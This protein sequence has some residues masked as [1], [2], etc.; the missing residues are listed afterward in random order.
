MELGRR[1]PA[2][3]AP[4][5]PGGG[6]RWTVLT[7]AVAKVITV[8]GTIVLA[9]ILVPADFGIVMLAFVA[10]NVIGLFGDLGLGATL[11]VRQDLDR[12]GLGTALSLLLGAGTLLGLVLAA[13]A[14]LLSDA[15]DE[16]RLRGV[17]TALAPLTVL[18]GLTWFYQWLLQRDLAFRT[19]F[20]GFVAQAAVY[21]AVAVGAAALG[22]G[23][24]S[25]V[26]GHLAGQAAMAAVF[27]TLYRPVWPRFDLGVARSLLRT[28]RGFLLQNTATLA[29]QNADYLA[30]GHTMGAAPLGFYSMAY[31]LSEL[32]HLAV[33]DP[34]R[35]VTFP[36]YSLM[37]ARGEDTRAHY[38]ATVRMV[39]LVTAPLGAV[40]S[41]AAGPF[42]RLVYGPRWE[43]MISALG[44]LAIWGAMKSVEAT[45]AWFLNSTGGA[46]TAGVVAAVVVAL[47]VPAL[48]LAAELGGIAAVAGV[49]LGGV[50]VSLGVLVLCLNR[51]IGV[52]PGP[53]LA[54]LW[55]VAV[56]SVGTWFAARAVTTLVSSPPS[57]SCVM[58]VTVGAAVY[59]GLISVLAPGSLP[60]LAR[61]LRGVAR[62]ATAPS[63]DP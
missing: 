56:A 28:S 40:L 59:V 9:R 34:V 4:P 35:R 48:F 27:L 62:G 15:L 17:L 16:P 41:A 26:A 44:V 13:V 33:A 3:P 2:E 45:V 53:H 31:R 6:V 58:A 60:A 49:L 32:P 52:G 19:R 22:A 51:R 12:R 36:T 25:I 11:V 10:I 63:T 57:A 43:P 8:A 37:R 50:T 42:T 39:A 38:L 1:Q 7:Y 14:P 18:G 21:A 20:F 30:I 61:Q 24:W 47:Q 55:P 46:A 23:V 29:Q 54:A 5:T